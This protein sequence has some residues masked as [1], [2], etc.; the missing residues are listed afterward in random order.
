MKI[1]AA[2]RSTIAQTIL[3]DMSAGTA[4]ANPIIEIYSGT[5]PA[6]MGGTITDTLIA[7]LTPTATVGTESGGVITFDAIAEDS[8]ADATATAGWA[9]IL[10]RDREEAVYLTITQI[11]GGGDLQLSSV[12]IITGLPVN[13]TS[14]VITVGGA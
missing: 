12:D 7:T 4:N 11:G 9:R 2:T 13:I 3:S 1:K 6:A 14:G 8:G 10:D 5:M